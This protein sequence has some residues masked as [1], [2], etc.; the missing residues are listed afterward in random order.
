[1]LASMVGLGADLPPSMIEGNEN[2]IGPPRPGTNAAIER[3]TWHDWSKYSS[4]Q[5]Y[6]VGGAG[7]IIVAGLAYLIFGRKRK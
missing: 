5:K 2:F 3:S 6:A 7:V 1:M 4:G